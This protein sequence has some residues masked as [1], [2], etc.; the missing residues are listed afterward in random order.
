MKNIFTTLFIFISTFCFSQTNTDG[1]LV[2]YN[3]KFN[4]QFGRGNDF[5]EYQGKLIIQGNQSL[6]TMKATG[7][8][9]PLDDKFN[10]DVS[11]D[12]LFTVYKDAESSS[13]I[14]DFSDVNQQILYFADT[15]HPMQ[16]AL[17]QEKKM[18]DQITCLKAHT[19]FK[20]RDYIAWYAP[21]IPIDNGPWK[22]GGLSGLILEAY[23][24]E[25]DWHLI[26]TSLK[27]ASNVTFLF[28]EKIIQKGLEG[29]E[30]Y[31]DY[32]QKIFRRIKSTLATAQT[33]D[34][35]TCETKS[36]VKLHTWEKIY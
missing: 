31:T 35:L 23:D 21:S 11:P 33:G 4:N 30:A 12:S 18:I 19:Q 17:T 22:L 34:C 29:Y 36:V 7:N 14:F 9:V 8:I 32:M 6:F 5:R 27:P 2:F 28:Y 24:S 16:W 25:D 20:G 26:C 3:G 10:I 13:L 1:F 15:L